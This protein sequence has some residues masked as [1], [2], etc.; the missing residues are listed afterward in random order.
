M[1]RRVPRVS[2]VSKASQSL[3]ATRSLT[4]TR[5]VAHVRGLTVADARIRFTVNRTSN[6]GRAQLNGIRRLLG[7]NPCSD[8]VGNV[9]EAQ[10]EAE[11]VG[12]VELTYVF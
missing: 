12:L 3:I 7:T 6:F 4:P 8:N 2:T 1:L 5:F 11:V 10:S 9:K